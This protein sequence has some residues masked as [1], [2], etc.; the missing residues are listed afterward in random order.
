ALYRQALYL[1]KNEN[2]A[3]DLVQETYLKAFRFLQDDK[4]VINEKAWLFRILINTFINQYRKGK[5]EPT[6]V[7][8]DSI[9]SFHELIE[10]EVLT[11]TIED[12]AKFDELLDSDVKRALEELPDDFRMVILLSTVEGFSYKEISQMLGCPIGTVMSRIYRGRRLLKEKLANYAEKRGF[13][14]E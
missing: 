9:E 6:L 11:S 14:E 2:N 5:K 8:F 12:A 4:G 10:E 13:K 7:D 3:E 1:V